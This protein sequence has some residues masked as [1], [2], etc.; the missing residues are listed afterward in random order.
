[1]PDDRVL[2]SLRII[3]HIA[4]AAHEA[5]AAY[6]RHIGE[7]TASWDESSVQVKESTYD[8]VVAVLTGRVKNPGDS[9]GN[10]LA[11]KASRGWKHGPIKSEILKEHPCFVPYP[12]LPDSQRFKDELFLTVVRGAARLAGIVVITDQ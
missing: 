11:Y 5:N 2:I 8:G 7:R 12:A 6:C 1:M 3:D 9:H 4:R 10:W